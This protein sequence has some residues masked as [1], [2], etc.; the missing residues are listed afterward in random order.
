MVEKEKYLNEQISLRVQYWISKMLLLGHHLL[1]FYRDRRLLHD[2]G[3]P[4]ALHGC[5]GRASRLVLVGGYYL[6]KAKRSIRYQYTLI[7]V[8]TLLSAMVIETMILQFGGHSSPYYAGLCLLIIAALGLI[9]YGFLLSLSVGITIYLI[10][11]L[12]I[13]FFDTITAP[14]MFLSPTIFS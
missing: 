5:T 14:S 6:N 13:F 4:E 2:A 11:L 7:T 10:Y 3:K 8:C 12:P 1:S 9:P